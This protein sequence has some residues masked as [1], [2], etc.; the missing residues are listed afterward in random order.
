[1]RTEARAVRAPPIVVRLGRS[2]PSSWRRPLAAPDNL[3]AHVDVRAR[4]RRGFGLHQHMH[5][6][7][8][9]VGYGLRLPTL[10]P[11]DAQRVGLALAQLVQ[12]PQTGPARRAINPVA[13]FRFLRFDRGL[14]MARV[15]GSPAGVER[16]AEGDRE[17]H[18]R[19]CWAQR[20]PDGKPTPGAR[21]RRILGPIA[22][23]PMSDTAQRTRELLDQ[24]L[25]QGGSPWGSPEAL[26]GHLPNRAHQEGWH[27]DWEAA[28]T[29]WSDLC[30]LGVVAI[31]GGGDGG[32][33]QG[34]PR[35]IVTDHGRSLFAR[36]ETS[37]HNADRYLN[38]VRSRV[39]DPDSIAM[40]YLDEAVGAWR[41]GLN[42]SSVVMLGGACERL[43]VLLAEAASASAIVPYSEKL[44]KVL[45]GPKPAGISDIFEQVRGALTADAEDGK[46]AGD[47]ADAIERKLSPIFEHARGLRNAHGHPSGAEVSDEDAEAGLLLFPGF[48]ALVDRLL[49]HF[50]GRAAAPGKA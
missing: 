18:R 42:R 23:G 49:A 26:L 13:T 12:L 38:A 50:R 47:L 46:M 1:M 7:P 25:S 40:T 27:L 24:L 5:G 21:Y 34:Y 37:P 2:R 4:D 22:N 6:A 19:T 45:K 8:A 43:I 29:H 36:G 11:L 10:S 9:A 17:P 16:Q 35:Y 30:R 31:V 15:G 44:A 28:L 39:A 3:V 14:S 48:Y 32:Y 41:S 20:R 33:T